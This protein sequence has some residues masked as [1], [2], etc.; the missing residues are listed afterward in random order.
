[1]ATPPTLPYNIS[2]EQSMTPTTTTTTTTTATLFFII[3]LT[4]GHQ[5]Q[6][7][8]RVESKSIPE[9]TKYLILNYIE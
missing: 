5:Q 3:C 1:M 8:G 2:N 4:M 9:R 6:N 7:E